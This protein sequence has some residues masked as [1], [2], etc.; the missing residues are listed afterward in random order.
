MSR[1]ATI[2]F[3]DVRHEYGQTMTLQSPAQTYRRVSTSSKEPQEWSIDH[4]TGSQVAPPS[5]VTSTPVQDA[6]MW[7]SSRCNIFRVSCCFYALFM[8]GAN[9]AAYGAL[10]PYVRSPFFHMSSPRSTD[11]HS[12]S[13]TTIS[14]TP[15]SRSSSYPQQSATSSPHSLT[16]SCT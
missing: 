10:I 15:S 9:D 14:H 7:N 13:A 8:M 16:T 11:S 4:G 3:Q 6:P 12:S 1:T 2:E 5:P